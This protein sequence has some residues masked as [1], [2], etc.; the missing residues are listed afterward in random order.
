MFRIGETEGHWKV[1]KHKTGGQRANMGMEKT[2]NRHLCQL[3]AKKVGKLYE[4]KDF[5]KFHG[6]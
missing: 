5:A 3:T 4:Y 1:T 2:R 6:R